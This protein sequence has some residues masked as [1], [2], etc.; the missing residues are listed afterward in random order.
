MLSKI[1]LTGTSK[2]MHFVKISQKAGV[3][4]PL[5]AMEGD[6]TIQLLLQRSYS[7]LFPFVAIEKVKKGQ[8]GN[9]SR[10]SCS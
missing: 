10:K 3:L 9:F 6:R 2:E 4:T 8:Y 1:L 5:K 7:V